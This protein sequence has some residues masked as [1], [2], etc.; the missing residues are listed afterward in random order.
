[1]E[2]EATGGLRT[3]DEI[4][5]EGDIKTRRSLQRRYQEM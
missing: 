1:M 3:L 2:W 4:K 5:I